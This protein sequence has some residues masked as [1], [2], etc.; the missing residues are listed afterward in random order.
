VEP[1]AM[2]TRAQSRFIAYAYSI[3]V[4]GE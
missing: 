3:G 1:F 4:V 2:V